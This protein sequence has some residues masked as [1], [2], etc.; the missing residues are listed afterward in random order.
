M[1]W[2]PGGGQLSSATVANA[3]SD[4]IDCSLL[5]YAE[6]LCSLLVCICMYGWVCV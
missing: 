6:I 3:E 5:Q 4:V 2:G 1:F